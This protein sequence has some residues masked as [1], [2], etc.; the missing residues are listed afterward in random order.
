[1]FGRY[2]K[3]HARFYKAGKFKGK[4]YVVGEYP[5]AVTYPAGDYY[6][7]GNIIQL[8]NP[9]ENLKHIDN[10]EGYGDGQLQPNLFIR[11]LITI[12]TADES[13]KCWVYL[14]NHPT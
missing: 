10:Y 7:R 8:N 13:I 4:L 3:Q 5:G 12:Q 9:I 1:E 11:E 6:V 2:L 14:Y